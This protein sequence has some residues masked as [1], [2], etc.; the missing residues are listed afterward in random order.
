[1]KTSE[2]HLDHVGP[3]RTFEG[4]GDDRSMWVRT[5]DIEGCPPGPFEVCLWTSYWNQAEDFP[6]KHDTSEVP[7][8][9]RGPR[10]REI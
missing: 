6:N 10:S 5:I 1:M 8:Q 2:G 3:V 7:L 4:L 9:N